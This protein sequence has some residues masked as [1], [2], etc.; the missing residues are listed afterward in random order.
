MNEQSDALKPGDLKKHNV[1]NA[2]G[3]P[4]AIAEA[5]MDKLRDASEPGDLEGVTYHC[6]PGC[7]LP[8]T[9]AWGSPR[10]QPWSWTQGKGGDRGAPTPRIRPA[11]P[12]T[13]LPHSLGVILELPPPSVTRRRQHRRRGACMDFFAALIATTSKHAGSKVQHLGAEANVAY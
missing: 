9:D 8:C 5:W 2:L 3:V 12:N 10:M 4:T 13:D 11:P 6:A 7:P 1:P